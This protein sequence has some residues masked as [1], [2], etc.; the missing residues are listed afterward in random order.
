A[1]G[2]INI[3]THIR[4]SGGGS[5]NLMSGWT[6]LEADFDDPL[7]WDN[8][9]DPNGSNRYDQ[10]PGPVDPEDVWEYYLEKGQFGAGGGSIL[11][12][13]PNITRSVE[14]GSRFGNTNV[15]GAN[16]FLVA[17][18]GNGTIRHV[19]LGFRDTGQV[20]SVRNTA[21]LNGG[22]GGVSA[23]DLN[24]RA[25]E[26][27]NDPIVGINDVAF[28]RDVNGD[29][30]P[31]GVYAINS[32]GVL[33]EDNPKVGGDGNG[34]VGDAGDAS[35]D[36][37]LIPFANHFMRVETGNYW[38]Q[39]LDPGDEARAAGFVSIAGVVDPLGLGGRSPEY[40]A[41]Q[42]AANRADINVVS[43]GA[44]I[45]QG[46]GRTW[47]YAQIGHGGDASQDLYDKSQNS[48]AIIDGQAIRFWSFN[49]ATNDRTATAIARL[50]PVF[51]NINILAG[52]DS[53]TV[54]YDRG[55]AEINLTGDT[56]D[57]AGTVRLL[58]WQPHGS[59][60]ANGSLETGNG[61]Q[62]YVQIGHLG[63]G[64]FGSTYGD[65]NIQAGGD[66]EL[67]AGSQTR[68]H[69]TIGHTMD[70]YNDWNPPS[71]LAQQIRFFASAEDFQDPDL[72]R[73]ELFADP[74]G[75][76]ARGFYPNGSGAG[77][78]NDFWGTAAETGSGGLAP[79]NIPVLGGLVPSFLIGD[80]RVDS[81]GNNGVDIIAYSTP[82]TRAY[83]FTGENVGDHDMDGI[84][85]QLGPGF[86]DDPDD[87]DGIRANRDRR[88]AGIGHG[89]SGFA[90]SEYFNQT[91]NGQPDEDVRLRINSGDG[92]GASS[93]SEEWRLTL[94]GN[95]GGT[96]YDRATTGVN[97]IGNID[98]HAH[99][100][101]VLVQ[102]GNQVFDYAYIGH[103]GSD[104]SD[105]ETSNVMIG[106]IS[107]SGAGNL[108]ILGGGVIAD[109]TGDANRGF[110]DNPAGSTGMRSYAIIGHHGDD[111][112]MQYYGGDIDAVFGGNIT[113]TGGGMRNSGAKIGHQTNRGFGQVGGSFSRNEEFIS[114]YL[115]ATGEASGVTFRATTLGSA[116]NGI[117]LDSYFDGTRTAQEVVDAWNT[118]NPGNT[119]ALASAADASLVL[120]A[121]T[122]VILDGG[123]SPH[124]L[125][126]VVDN[127]SATL[128]IDG[129]SLVVPISGYTTNISVAALGD[130]LMTHDDPM[131]RTNQN[132]YAFDN[133]GGFN[134]ERFTAVQIG[135]GG[136]A[137]GAAHNTANF[138]TAYYYKD[139]T[140]NISVSAGEVDALTG[141]I[142]GGNITM[143]NGSGLEYWTVIGH[144]F[145]A[146][147]R[148]NGPDTVAG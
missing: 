43:T 79:V 6:G 141:A 115:P 110:D 81:Y 86:T 7:L 67:R 84:A 11:M 68:S 74:Y 95:T 100:G 143:Q 138:N 111:A 91:A 145:G 98:V 54:L 3:Q 108:D 58:G 2:N 120:A 72:R 102:A 17:S 131:L 31:D 132:Q 21:T 45:L 59:A 107:V 128:T 97:L 37:T 121:G 117:T 69:A 136:T 42:S 27:D 71:N 89:G 134:D 9:F 8:Y 101:D 70:G 105:Y 82:D 118:D 46:G 125:S 34:I 26:A 4:T 32:F 62:A 10:N 63:V 23:L 83:S 127:S 113:L 40:G 130:I 124:T 65:I 12:G 137:T 13:G 106:D 92:T 22:A 133:D 126:A 75:G 44:V 47:N 20:F 49:G 52:V 15:A 5:I 60:D 14:V 119:I 19:Q 55:A 33:N 139:K 135:H 144:S 116:G 76:T 41:G 78:F 104:L 57:T 29:T 64:Q 53:S 109:Y 90:V 77:N 93:L 66:I 39:Q 35:A 103:G 114:D 56:P 147:D 148:A 142:S 30:V 80:I 25:L 38:W 28:Y 87:Q 50:A 96:A 51:G 36:P 1:G 73:G 112:G 24:A 85:A 18:Q 48:T 123:S 129:G 146:G 94:A 16:V 140:G 61:A 88:F 122:S 99:N